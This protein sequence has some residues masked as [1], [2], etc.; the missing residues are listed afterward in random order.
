MS[1]FVDLKWNGD[2]AGGRIYTVFDPEKLKDPAV[3]ETKKLFA[4]GFA[5]R[6]PDEL[7]KLLGHADLRVRQRAQFAL[8]EK[9]ETDTLTKAAKEG[10]SQFARLHTVVIP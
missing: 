3:Q 6:K 7:A 1:D 4:G 9:R 2:S 5:L 8:A 10:S